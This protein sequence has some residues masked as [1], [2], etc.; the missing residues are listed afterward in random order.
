MNRPPEVLTNAAVT[1]SRWRAAD[2]ELCYRIISE[3]A[4]HLAPW[5]A[6]ATPDYSLDRA[7]DH[8][9]RCEANWA[10]GT[11]FQY[12]ILVQG[13]PAGSASLMA[14]IGDRALE[15]GY[16]VHPA[17]TGRGV[18]T[19]AA[20]ALTDAALALPAIDQVEIHH[21]VRN[22]ASERVP[23]KLGY[24]FIE[25]AKTAP[26]LVAPGD[27]GISKVWRITR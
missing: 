10:D 22:V 17:W 18:A 21:D 3:S 23:A 24:A 6:W 20:A 9:C 2:A 11:A 14:R 4:D 15:I 1:L 19:S 25:E 7:T 12:L 27:A 8:V 26:E 13:N 5:M 16:W